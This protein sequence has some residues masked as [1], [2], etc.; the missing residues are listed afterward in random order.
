[1]KKGSRVTQENDT[2]EMA[3]GFYI[4]DMEIYGN[5]YLVI[6]FSDPNFGWPMAAVAKQRLHNVA[7]KTIKRKQLK[8]FWLTTEG[9]YEKN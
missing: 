8:S 4:A 3:V 2:G 7:W 1:M 5:N 9:H 6:G